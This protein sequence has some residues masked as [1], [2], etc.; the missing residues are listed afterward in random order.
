MIFDSRQE[1]GKL[2]GEELLRRGISAS[3]VVG[4][5]RGGVV[6][7]AEVA[8]AFKK[9]LEVMIVRK[10]GAPGSPEFAVG[11][12]AEDTV[13]WDEET[14]RRMGLTE[15]WKKEQVELKRREIEEYRKQLGFGDS[16]TVL[17]R[18]ARMSDSSI[19]HSRS[20]GSLNDRP[21]SKNIVGR[22]VKKLS[23]DQFP[24]KKISSSLKHPS[25]S[26]VLVDD[27]AATGTSMVAAI[28]SLRTM[29]HELRTKILVALPV[30]STDAAEKFRAAADDVVL[31]EE[32]SFLSSV[33]Q[34]YRDF[35]Q[36]E[37][38]EV[39]RLLESTHETHAGGHSEDAAGKDD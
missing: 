26:I 36:V 28:Q 25:I 20:I 15:E 23:G 6:V 21:N 34:Y 31:L 10:I 11:A 35:S 9:P 32:G 1:A 16:E 38:E 5:A 33:G 37:W 19:G 3:T 14:V 17:S 8:R 24:R 12:M 30:T 39:R 13:W 18:V 7:A 4:L 2:L 27:G 29:N 22:N